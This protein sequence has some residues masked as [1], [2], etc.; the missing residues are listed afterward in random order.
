LIRTE[1]SDKEPKPKGVK[2]LKEG[3][4]RRSDIS[5]IRKAYYG[6]PSNSTRALPLEKRLE[7]TH[8]RQ[9]R[10]LQV[11]GAITTEN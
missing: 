4:L 9:R 6:Q 3:T 7:W 2:K 1:L 11:S 5:Y 10:R 8:E